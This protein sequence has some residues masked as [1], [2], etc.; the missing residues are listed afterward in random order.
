MRK[1]SVGIFTMKCKCG[2]KDKDHFND[3]DDNHWETECKICE[4]I[5][6]NSRTNA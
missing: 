6:F 3:G 1:V 2:H 5:W 4:C